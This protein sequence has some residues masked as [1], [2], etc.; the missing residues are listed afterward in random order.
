MTQPGDDRGK[1]LLIDFDGTLADTLPGLRSV[2]A[3]FLSDHRGVPT[4]AEFDRL[5]GIP[6]VEIVAALKVEHEIAADSTALER[7]YLDRVANAYEKSRPSAGALDLLRYARERG[8]RIAVVTSGVREIVQVWLE[9]NQLADLVLAVIEG[10]D[11][12]EGKPS[13]APYQ[14]ALERLGARACDSVAIE[15]SPI[16]AQSAVAAGVTTYVLAVQQ[17]SDHESWPGVAGFVRDLGDVV[18]LL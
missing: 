9:R 4:D 3:Q 16:G 17:K 8:Y 12:P 7:D 5:N 11:V 13:P 10:K 15:D 18:G 2:Y 14:L 1:G 6:M